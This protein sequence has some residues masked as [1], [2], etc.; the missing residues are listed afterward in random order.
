M[1]YRTEKRQSQQEG[2]PKD[3]SDDLEGFSFGD[4]S[5]QLTVTMTAGLRCP[6][7]GGVYSTMA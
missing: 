4:P 7:I 6:V 2:H 5:P 1:G 3:T